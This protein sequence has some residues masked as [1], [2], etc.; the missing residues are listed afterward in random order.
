MV[1]STS[2]VNMSISA[3]SNPPTCQ[4]SAPGYTPNGTLTINVANGTGIGPFVYTLTA[5]NGTQTATS[6][7]RVYTF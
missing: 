5:S 4:N 2:Y 7:N 3:T 1:I 6:S